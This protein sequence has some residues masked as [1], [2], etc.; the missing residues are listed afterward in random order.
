MRANTFSLIIILHTNEM[1]TFFG[2]ANEIYELRFI[3]SAVVF[4]YLFFFSFL[5]LFYYHIFGLVH[6]EFCFLSLHRARSQ[7]IRTKGNN[8]QSC[9]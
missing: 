4:I 7:Q 6:F 2:F 1:A 5:Q 8:L 3:C 9:W